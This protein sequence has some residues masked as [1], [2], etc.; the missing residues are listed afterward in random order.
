MNSEKRQK[1]LLLLIVL[2][3]LIQIHVLNIVFEKLFVLWGD[4]LM[5]IPT[6]INMQKEGRQNF[7]QLE[8][9]WLL[10]AK[11]FKLS[12]TLDILTPF[13]SKHLC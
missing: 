3:T 5:Y 7:K 4:D 13:Y 10:S 1:S 11:S 2:K 9:S 6:D 8:E 12:R